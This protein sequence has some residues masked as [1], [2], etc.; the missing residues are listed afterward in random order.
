MFDPVVLLIAPRELY[1][2]PLIVIVSLTVKPFPT[3][4]NVPVEL[5]VVLLAAVPKAPALEICNI[6]F[7][8]VVAPV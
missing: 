6:P 8:I 4:C 2:S 3:I 5:M 7:P 1:P